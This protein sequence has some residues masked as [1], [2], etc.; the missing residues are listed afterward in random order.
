MMVEKKPLT[1][2]EANRILA[3]AKAERNR[4]KKSPPH[5][6]NKKQWLPKK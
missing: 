1:E 3:K 4:P 5:I 2:E 6:I